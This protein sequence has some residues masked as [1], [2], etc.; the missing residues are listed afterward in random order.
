MYSYMYVYIHIYEYI[1]IYYKEN[2]Y[3]WYVCLNAYTYMYVSACIGAKLCCR[4]RRE[5]GLGV[6]G[7]CLCAFGIQPGA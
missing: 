1:Y 2:V 6:P 7:P 3:V 5:W 4:M